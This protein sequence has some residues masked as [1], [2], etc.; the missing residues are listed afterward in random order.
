MEHFA[1]NYFGTYYYDL[2][3]EKYDGYYEYS[4]EEYEEEMEACHKEQETD[5][6][7]REAMPNYHPH[8]SLNLDEYWHEANTVN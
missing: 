8:G 6:L 5:L 3:G 2:F 4:N 1:S 7:F